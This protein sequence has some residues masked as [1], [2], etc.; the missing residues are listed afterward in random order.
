[1]EQTD[2]QRVSALTTTITPTTAGSFNFFGHVTYAPQT[3]TYQNI[4]KLLTHFCKNYK[5]KR[6]YSLISDSF[7]LFNMNISNHLNENRKV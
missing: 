5:F 2:A 7:K 3:F 4:A 6:I 1:M